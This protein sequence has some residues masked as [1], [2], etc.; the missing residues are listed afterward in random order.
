MSLYTKGA[1]NIRV[2]KGLLETNAKN[3]QNLVE[4]G[5]FP[6]RMDLFFPQSMLDRLHAELT[7][8]VIRDRHQTDLLALVP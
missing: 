5:R 2:I 8:S 6:V 3:G 7:L 4:D 1:V